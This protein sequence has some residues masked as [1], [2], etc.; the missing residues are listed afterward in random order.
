MPIAL[1]EKQEQLRLRILR[2]A[3][4]HGLESEPGHEIGDLHAAL[5]AALAFISEGDL[6]KLE[7]I[8]EEELEWD[9][10]PDSD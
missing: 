1:T 6:P 9:P 10:C 7:A 4:A 3:V 5:H 2:A 8:L